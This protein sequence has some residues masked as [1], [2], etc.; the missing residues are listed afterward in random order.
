MALNS[1]AVSRLT[2]TWEVSEIYI[3][4]NTLLKNLY[5]SSMCEWQ[6]GRANLF[7]SRDWFQLSEETENP[8]YCVWVTCI[9]FNK[10]RKSTLRIQ[11]KIIV[12]SKLEG[13]MHC[14]FIMFFFQESTK[15]VP[16]YSWAV[17]QYFGKRTANIHLYFWAHVFS[18]YKWA[19]HWNL[20]DLC[21]SCR[22][23]R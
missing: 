22:A 14:C 23:A 20:L 8:C 2:Q 13:L 21:C 15:E 6:W 18:S 12:S 5:E 19:E 3:S 10:P 16:K 9:F 7:L 4:K 1:V 11:T 17:W